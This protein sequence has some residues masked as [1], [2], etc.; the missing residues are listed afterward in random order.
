MHSL[1]RKRNYEWINIAKGIAIILVVY[2]HNLIG[3]E[4][5][6]FEIPEIFRLAN[7]I[8]YSFRMPLF[9]IISGLFISKSIEKRQ[10]TSFINYKFNSI[11]Y[12]YLI[13]GIIQISLQ[14]VLSNYTNSNRS[15]IDFAYLIISPRQVDQLWY[16]FALFNCS[17]LFYF[18][19]SYLRI[20]PIWHLIIAILMFGSSVFL[21]DFNLI[22]DLFYYYIFLTLGHQLR[23]LIL[24]EGY[25][26]KQL[27]FSV[28]LITPLFWFSQWYWLN[29][30]DLN[31]FLFGFIALLGTLYV[32]IIARV[33]EDLKWLNF[34]KIAGKYSLQIYLMH[35]LVISG[36][37]IIVS[38]IFNLELPVIVLFI[39]WFLGNLIPI[40]FYKWTQHTFLIYLFQPKKRQFTD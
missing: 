13:W 9:F 33:V 8:V 21:T 12:P 34:I 17:I 38:K 4:R 16:L 26:K 39:G 5:S 32:F 1:S 37:R 19:H 18:L 10:E 3:L 40:L 11:Y 6:G 7:E 36:F 22:H 30:P 2:R 27:V 20:Q 25:S 15:W 31:L 35:V 23:S 24:G 29:N 14:I 28:I